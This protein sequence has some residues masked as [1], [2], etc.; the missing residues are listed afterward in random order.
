MI[1]LQVQRSPDVGPHLLQAKQRCSNSLQINRLTEVGS[2]KKVP[3]GIVLL[4]LQG[5]PCKASS[6]IVGAQTFFRVGIQIIAD[7]K[8]QT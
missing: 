8:I 6:R 5:A 7:I 1:F 3:L 2:I 4:Q